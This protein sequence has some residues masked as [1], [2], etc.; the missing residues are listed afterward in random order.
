MSANLHDSVLGEGPDVVLLHGLFGMGGNL[1]SLARALQAGYRVHS[2]DLPNHGRSARRDEAWLLELANAVA[3]WM[4][5]RHLASAAFVGHSLG[6]K[7]AMQLALTQPARVDSLVVADI[8]PV[9]YTPRHEAVFAALDA[10]AAADCRSRGEAGQ[11]MADYIKEEGVIQFLLL[12]LQRGDSG[13]YSWRFN[14]EA[15]KSNYDAIQ[16]APVLDVA[17]PGRALFIKGGDSDY[18]LPEHQEQILAR[19]PAADME[20]M[21]GCGHW[22]HAQQPERFNALVRDF[23]DG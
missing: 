13:R 2:I 10:V 9:D 14:L 8:A 18:I 21:A 1:G 19:F 11:L 23:L 20:V 22:L 16:R 7:V 12:S 15:L 5:D 17:Y 4:D 6:G 3:S